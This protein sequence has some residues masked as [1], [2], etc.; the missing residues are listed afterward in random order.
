MPQRVMI[1]APRN[2]FPCATTCSPLIGQFLDLARPSSHYFDCPI[3]PA[4][5]PELRHS[6]TES[7]RPLN[8]MKAT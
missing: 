1:G 5:P 7:F 4:Q 2:R 6:Q 3:F 8:E